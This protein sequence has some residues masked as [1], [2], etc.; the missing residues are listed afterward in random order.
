MHVDGCADYIKA[1]HCIFHDTFDRIGIY[2][3]PSLNLEQGMMMMNLERMSISISGQRTSNPRTN[4][5]KSHLKVWQGYMKIE[6]LKLMKVIQENPLILKPVHQMNM[7]I[8]L[9]NL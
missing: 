4:V 5:H 2:G 6:Q 8:I 1:L 7:A 9:S 3:P